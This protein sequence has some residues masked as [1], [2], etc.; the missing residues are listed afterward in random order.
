MKYNYNNCTIR[1]GIIDDIDELANLYDE[2]ND[3]LSSGI[4]YPGWRKD[5]YPTRE[6]A[7]AAVANQTLYVA[8]QKGNDSNKIV[9]SI[10][11]NHV[12]ENAYKDGNWA[13]NADYKDIFVVHTFAVHPLFLKSG[14][15]QALLDFTFD[16]AQEMQMKAV[17]LDVYE[18]N[19]PAIALYEKNGFRYAGTVDLGYGGHG[20][21]WFKLYEAEINPTEI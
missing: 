4:N 13:I 11:L 10:I 6:T 8:I 1:K 7:A 16:F 5:I 18:K 15:G 2:L 14:I 9:G 20:L 19:A 21:D 12:E 17:R 3:Y